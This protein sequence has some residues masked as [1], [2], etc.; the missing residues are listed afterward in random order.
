MN[1]STSPE[2]PNV[3]DHVKIQ[4]IGQTDAYTTG[5]FAWLEN[6]SGTRCDNHSAWRL[7][8]WFCDDFG[9]WG[10]F[11]SR[12]GQTEAGI[13]W[14][15][16]AMI[17]LGWL[18]GAPL[19]IEFDDGDAS[20]AVDESGC[21]WCVQVHWAFLQLNLA[22]SCYYQDAVVARLPIKWL[23]KINHLNNLSQFDCLTGDPKCRR[24]SVARQL[25]WCRRVV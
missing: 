11:G 15:T 17:V 22:S 16:I 23:A 3:L 21:R 18:C 1:S 24:G 6:H 10:D 8:C 7:R 2:T 19:G 25:R 14:S 20:I 4:I 12:T 9:V 13:R 5:H